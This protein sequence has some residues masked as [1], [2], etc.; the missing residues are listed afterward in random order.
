[1]SGVPSLN[2]SSSSASASSFPSVATMSASAFASTNT[3]SSSS[4][5]MMPHSR[6]DASS[7]V[8]SV[9]ALFQVKIHGLEDIALETT[10]QTK[11]QQNNNS[12]NNSGGL[13]FSLSARGKNRRPTT[14]ADSL[15]DLLQ[16]EYSVTWKSGK[17]KV[18]YFFQSNG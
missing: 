2:L 11:Q 4:S 9:D 13:Q 8:M 16:Y 5:A 14:I 15:F 18:S 1:M 6:G 12:N 17:E 10:N 7:A 3:L